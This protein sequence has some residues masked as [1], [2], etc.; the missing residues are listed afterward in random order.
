MHRRDLFKLAAAAGAGALVTPQAA[1]AARGM[2]TRASH[3]VQ[4]TTIGTSSITKRKSATGSLRGRDQRPLK[5][6]L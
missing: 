5:E 3:W 4:N 1:R 2:S 6:L